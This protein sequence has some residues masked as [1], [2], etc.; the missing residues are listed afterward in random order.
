LNDTA[1]LDAARGNYASA[2]AQL[3]TAIPIGRRTLGER[4]PN[5]AAVLN[6]FSRMLMHQGKY[7]EAITALRESLRIAVP[8]LGS[9][10]PLV[11]I[12]KI[13]LASAY[14]AHNEAAAAEPL[15]REGL[16]IRI[17]APGVVPSRR[18]TLPEDDWSVGATR[19]LLGATLTTLKRYDEAEALLLAARHDLE[20]TPGAQSPEAKAT[21]A[22]LV[23]LYVAWG[24]PE[25]AEAYRKLL[26]S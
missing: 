23:A 21:I 19:S 1:L 14:I 18:R 26:P 25:K 20:I 2:E 24:R 13:N 16:Q 9:E 10:H 3:R 17:R 22:R 15:L 6:N 12:Y 7:D 8:A 5:V 4:H 11:G